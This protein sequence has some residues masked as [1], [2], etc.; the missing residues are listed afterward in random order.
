MRWVLLAGIGLWGC[1]FGAGS[2]NKNNNSDVD[3]GPNPTPDAMVDAAPPPIDAPP[4]P[5]DAPPVDND[6]DRDGVL[7]PDD[8][9]PVTANPRQAN[10]DGDARGDA[11]DTCPW[12]A[13]ESSEDADNDHLTD[14][15]DPDPR[16]ADQ[17][18]YFEGFDK[19]ATG[20]TLPQGWTARTVSGEWTVSTANGTMT[21]SHPSAM[22]Q[23]PSLIGIDLGAG[24][25]TERLYV[26]ATAQFTDGGNNHRQ[27]GV[28]GDL[29]VASVEGPAGAF[30]EV[31]LDQGKSVAGYFRATDTG[32]EGNSVGS[33]A[34]PVLLRLTVERRTGGIVQCDAKGVTA[35]SANRGDDVMSRA[36]TGIGFRV[37]N[38]TATFHH[39]AA[40]RL[41]ALS[42]PPSS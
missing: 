3:G 16:Y 32:E 29:D 12:K 18:I 28:V 10:D 37:A 20:Q 41:N 35:G 23:T 11:C 22:I 6:P 14:E 19:L 25:F 13:N 30:C 17:L 39:V 38:G 34:S 26:R 42:K 15:C 36:G 40:F 31:T 33:L 9:C 27:A 8:N 2:N 1:G 24:A 5:I 4:P 21:G 7:N